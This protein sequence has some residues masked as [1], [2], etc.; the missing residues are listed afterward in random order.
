MF[1]ESQL[2]QPLLHTKGSKNACTSFDL[3]FLADC[4]NCVICVL[5]HACVKSLS[6]ALPFNF[7]DCYIDLFECKH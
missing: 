5:V 7:L 4:V 3:T 1:S 6:N 2:K